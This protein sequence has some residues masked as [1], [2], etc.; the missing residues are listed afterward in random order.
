MKLT[1]ELY[2]ALKLSPDR[3]GWVKNENGQRIET[4]CSR[5][6]AIDRYEM[7][8]SPARSPEYVQ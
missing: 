4:Q 5:C 3:C 1:E 6:K 8:F 7:E 2:R